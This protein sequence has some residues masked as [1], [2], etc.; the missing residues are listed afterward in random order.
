[1]SRRGG[2]GMASL[3]IESWSECSGK[4]C[5]NQCSGKP[6]Q[7]PMF[8]EVV[9]DFDM[10]SL[11]I[12]NVEECSG[13][14]CQGET[15]CSGKPCHG[16]Q[17]EC[18]LCLWSMTSRVIEILRAALKCADARRSASHAWLC[19]TDA[20]GVSLLW[21]PSARTAARRGRRVRRPMAV[22]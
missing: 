2:F 13:K 11:S 6:C 19:C 4:P 17:I 14:P 10:A 22:G 16:L 9:S 20:L 15:Q 21:P 1:M 5:Q 7:N 8:G 18:K 12:E 3:N